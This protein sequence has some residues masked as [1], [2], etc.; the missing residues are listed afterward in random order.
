MLS[1]AIQPIKKIFLPYL[2]KSNVVKVIIA[3]LL[4]VLL[5]K[6]FT[7]ATTVRELPPPPLPITT[8]T[9][10]GRVLFVDKKYVKLLPHPTVFQCRR[11]LSKSCGRT[12]TLEKPTKIVIHLTDSKPGHDA[13]DVYDYFAEG[14]PLD[15]NGIKSLRGVGVDFI[16]DK[17]GAVYQLTNM[18][19]DRKEQSHGTYNYANEINIELVNTES[20][21]SSVSDLPPAQYLSLKTLIKNLMKQYDIPLGPEYTWQAPSDNEVPNLVGVFGHYQ[22][23]P[24]TKD[25]PGINVMRSLRQ[26]IKQEVEQIVSYHFSP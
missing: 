23:N 24:E 13:L 2:L 11:T 6:S 18:Y 19:K 26:D 20:S 9:T 17:N 1:S 3:F 25:D 7:A 22:L 4:T 14:S 16:A 15:E 10:D 21:V 8:I 5:L 12:L